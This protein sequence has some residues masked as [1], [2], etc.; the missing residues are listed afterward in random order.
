MCG[1]GP[2][3]GIHDWH[4]GQRIL[5]F[6]KAIA[7][8]SFLINSKNGRHTSIKRAPKQYLEEVEDLHALVIRPAAAFG[9]YPVDDLIG[10]HDVAGLAVDA[11]GK[12]YL[13]PAPF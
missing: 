12:V 8:D 7:F 5:N 2:N 11:V 4:F 9:G 10:I 6:N 1:P 13:Q 3:G